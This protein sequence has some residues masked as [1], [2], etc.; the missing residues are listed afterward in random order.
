MNQNFTKTKALMMALAIILIGIANA[1]NTPRV[2]VLD[3]DADR[4][5]HQND[6][7]QL[8]SIL[9]VHLQEEFEVL[10]SQKVNEEI[11]RIVS[12][13]GFHRETLTVQQMEIV[14]SILNLSKIITGSIN[15][16][17]GA[18]FLLAS[19][20]DVET[21]TAK[22]TVGATGERDVPIRRVA[23]RLAQNLM[24]EIK[25]S[26]EPV[27]Q[28]IDVE[29]LLQ[30][31]AHHR[32]VLING[33]RWAASNV[34]TQ[35]GT[36]TASPELAGRFNPWGIAT[37]WSVLG[38]RRLNTLTGNEQPRWGFRRPE[39]GV[40]AVFVSEEQQI[41][42]DLFGENHIP[43]PIQ[44]ISFEDANLGDWISSN[45][46]PP[47]WRVPYPD[48]FESLVAAGS[49]WTTVN[50]VPGR[51]FGTPP[52]QIFLP[53]AGGG[54]IDHTQDNNPFH[55]A[56]EGQMGYY[57]TRTRQSDGSAWKFQFSQVGVNIHAG[58]DR[59]NMRFGYNIRCVLADN[60]I[61]IEF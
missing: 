22:T 1:Q 40:P 31:S 50:G 36:F 26:E 19:V 10:N 39:P 9:T 20:L 16:R 56:H 45:P 43:P 23:P 27:P 32:G 55:V 54:G 17:H 12:E 28:E 46:C 6:V 5:I 8:T 49:F 60:E 11:D 58:G 7:A 37:D 30:W 59:H 34:D 47:G 42:E 25:R 29:T 51:V 61:L 57:W 18:F 15:R 52:N 48:E 35:I 4:N 33:V 3:F 13:Q 24:E 21:G 41:E 44:Q 2:L 53:A 38:T 14:D